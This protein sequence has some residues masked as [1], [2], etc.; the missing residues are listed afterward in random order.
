M[1]PDRIQKA[2]EAAGQDRTARPFT[3]RI[4]LDESRPDRVAVIVV[5]LDITDDELFRL[6]AK[7]MVDGRVAMAARREMDARGALVVAHALPN[8]APLS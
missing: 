2:I 5:P 3:L 6:C 8:G 7:V 4:G 1:P